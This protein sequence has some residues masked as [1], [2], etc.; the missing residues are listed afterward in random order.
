MTDIYYYN[1]LTKSVNMY[2]KVCKECG[3]EFETDRK[4]RSFCSR[5]CYDDYLSKHGTGGIRYNLPKEENPNYIKV[6]CEICGKEEYVLNHRAQVYKTCSRE[7]ASKY[8]SQLN[9][10]R[11]TLTCPICGEEYECKQSKTKHHRTCGKPECRKS[12]LK[13]T[14]CG[15]NNTNYKKVED[16]IRR[17]EYGECRN[18]AIH[19]HI[20]KEYFNLPNLKSL[21]KGYHIHHKDCNHDNNDIH[22]LVLLPQETHMLLHRIFGNVLLSALHTGRM[23]RETFFSILTDKQKEFYLNII[24]LDITHQAVVKQGELLENPEVDNQHPSVYRN[25]YVGST[26]N[27]RVQTDNA[28]DGNADTSALPADDGG[29]DIV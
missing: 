19:Q 13:K 9:S 7:C 26:T 4:N 2:K 8:L 3:N 21:P 23:D 18:K 24:D 1:N 28:V 11:V 22:N 12:W 20:V 27:S 17:N 15:K 6:K 25:I 14:K 16:L 10:K 5:K 29:E